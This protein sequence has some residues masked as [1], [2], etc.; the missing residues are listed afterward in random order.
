MERSGEL[1]ALGAEVPAPI[2]GDWRLWR[3]EKSLALI[4][5]TILDILHQPC[6]LFKK[7]KVSQT[8]FYLQS[9]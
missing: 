8:G 3:I 6:L 1:H 5:I 7:K 2:R 4:T 9:G